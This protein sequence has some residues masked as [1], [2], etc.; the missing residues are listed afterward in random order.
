M[1]MNVFAGVVL[2]A[3][4]LCVR[5]D[6]DLYNVVP[7]SPGREAEQAAR[8]V[9][10]QE[11]TGV[12]LA[13]YSLSLH[14]EGVPATQKVDRYL[15]SYEKFRDAL[16]GS[17]VHPAILVQSI[18][19]HWPRVDKDIEPWMRT[20]DQDGKV[21]RFCPL[22]EGFG[23]YIDYV[24]T[25]V[26][27]AHPSFVLLDDD[28]RAF[29]HGAECFCDRHVAEFNRR[30]GTSF[31]S[32][33]LRKAVAE[34]NP[35]ER[36]YDGFLA[37]QREMIEEHVV[38]RIRRAIDAVD[39]SVRGGICV[40]GEEHRFCLSLARRIAAQGQVPVM[41]ASTGCYDERMSCGRVPH[42]VLRMLGFAE[43]YRGE[44]VGILNEADTCPQNLWS[45]SSRSFF[46]HLAV[47]DFIGFHGAKTWYVNG[48]RANGFYV[49]QA[50]TDVLSENSGFLGA[51]A[52]EVVG[53]EM[54]G[55][56][57]PC[58]T[59]FPN[60]H[61]VKNHDE[62]FM[63]AQSAG[64]LVCTPFGIP[65]YASRDFGIPDRVYAIA[66]AEE[67]R[68]LS[69]EDCDLFLS[70]NVI[71]FRDAALELT[72]RG[73]EGLTG[74]HAELTPMKFNAEY[75]LRTEASMVYS[76]AMDGSVRFT[77]VEGCER[78][79][80]FIYRPYAGVKERE[81]VSPASVLFKNRL[82][83]T[84]VTVA[85]HDGMYG[86][87][88]YSEARKAWLLNIVDRLSSAPLAF[89]LNDQD[90]LVLERQKPDGTRLVL[91]ENLNSEPIRDLRL[92]IPPERRIERLMPN[93]VWQFAS[94]KVSVGFYETV[95]LRIR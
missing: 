76:P 22:D 84:V 68:R 58:F 63:Q 86:L 33:S 4:T 24:F 43:Y 59:N 53:S 91:V 28:V 95:V 2:S 13:L 1:N 87:H 37:L 42:N 31:E 34:S 94:G 77:T 89:C 35:G 41:R 54:R 70:G 6:Y 39:P 48:L 47:S 29:S 56:A 67:V 32:G 40:A 61:V 64:P 9:D 55:L 23:A 38:G 46:S 75:D 62:F 44:T 65:F 82:G 36:I 12:D 93:G 69:D 30:F 51:L 3:A 74:V 72:K 27:R 16:K 18:L 20:V 10:L 25:A 81:T 14:P 7:M 17:K 83:G 45:K 90:V 49:T 79:S 19:G 66:S 80:D 8:S 50:Y 57:L 21:V 11:R 60:W 78:I 92:R 52:K 85:Y 88:R 73:K 5:A 15:S 26:A 71:V